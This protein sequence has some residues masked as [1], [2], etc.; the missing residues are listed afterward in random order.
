[1]H[2]IKIQDQQTQHKKFDIYFEIKLNVAGRW[3]VSELI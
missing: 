1:M 3:G 2:N